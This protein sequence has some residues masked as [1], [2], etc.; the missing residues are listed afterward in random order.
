[1]N[2]FDGHHRTL[3]GNVDDSRVHDFLV[4]FI[5]VQLFFSPE[6]VY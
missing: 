1:M 4:Q 5:V 3:G 6:K 2:V